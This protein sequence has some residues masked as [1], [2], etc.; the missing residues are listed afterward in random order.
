M[1]NVS[2]G[3]TAV[4][5]AFQADAALTTLP[6]IDS[7]SVLGLQASNPAAHESARHLPQHHNLTVL[8]SEHAQGPCRT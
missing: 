4:R 8:N 7:A 1:Q 6:W 3:I 5:T 2:V